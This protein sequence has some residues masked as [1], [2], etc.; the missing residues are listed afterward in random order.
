VTAE[1]TIPAM[2][3]SPVKAGREVAKPMHKQQVLIPA[4]P[5]IA[6]FLLPNLSA[7]KPQNT[8]IALPRKYAHCSTLRK[9]ETSISTHPVADGTSTMIC[10]DSEEDMIASAR[11]SK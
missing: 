4:S 10:V 8:P 11:N 5:S 1:L 2:N 3:L 7:T 6:T 9:N